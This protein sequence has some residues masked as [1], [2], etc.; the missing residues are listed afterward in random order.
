MRRLLDIAPLVALLG[1]WALGGLASA[2][3]VVQAEGSLRHLA[4]GIVT[5]P[6]LVLVGQALRRAWRGAGQ[7]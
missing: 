5:L 2:L 4:L 1:V 6:A 7:L 3:V